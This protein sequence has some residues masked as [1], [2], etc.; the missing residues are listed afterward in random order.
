MYNLEVGRINKGHR[1][2]PPFDLIS[3]ELCRGLLAFTALFALIAPD[4]GAETITQAQY[5]NPVHRY[6]HFALGQPHEYS[7]LVVTTDTGH[8]LELRLP[9]F[10]VFEDF[11]PR[12]VRLMP[13]EPE[14]ILSIVSSNESGSRLVLIKISDG[15]LRI[16]AQSRPIGTPMRWLNPVAVTDLDGDGRAEIAAV[17]TPHI[18]GT[19]KVYRRAGSDLVE[20]AALAGFSNHVYGS[21]ELRLSSPVLI[22]DR[23]H[24]LVPDATR[25]YLRIIAFTGDSLMEMGR[26]ELR[27]PVTGPVRVMPS[28]EITVGYRVGQQLI[29]LNDCL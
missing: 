20:V 9:E 21:P 10:E 13:G 26:C 16:S 23:M 11:E 15:R 18:G 6:G 24:L 7:R 12:L 25:R 1:H 3:I 29:A 2:G 22:A 19:L 17:I 5:R 27:Q 28:S 8:S 14:E 4:V